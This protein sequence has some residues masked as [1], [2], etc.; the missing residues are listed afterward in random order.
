M[1]A[2]KAQIMFD[3]LIFTRIF[4]TLNLRK[5]K[6]LARILSLALVVM[7]RLSYMGCGKDDD[8]KSETDQQIDKLNGTWK[9]SSVS[10]GGTDFTSDYSNF[11]I[12]LSA[13][14]GAK[15]VGYA[16][17]GRPSGKLGP[18]QSTGLLQFGATPSTK[19]T[20]DDGTEVTYAATGT[21]LDMSFTY[22][23]E[24]YTGRTEKISGDWV[25]RFT[26]Q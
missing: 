3:I 19:L 22:T 24:G 18:W 7:A 25:F 8:A 10:F 1:P 21:T 17:A 5:M 20:R 26:K 4:A 9:A 15:S 11:T 16:T 23:G 13:T 6:H 12:T 14:A 2:R